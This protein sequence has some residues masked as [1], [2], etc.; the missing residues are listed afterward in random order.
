MGD[1]VRIKVC[2]LTRE[3]DVGLAAEL[4]AWAVGFV[5][6][7][8]SPRAVSP[9]QAARIGRAAGAVPRVGVFVDAPL[10]EL[11]ATVDTAGLHAVQLHGEESPA[12]CARVRAALPGVA[13]YK[14]LRL[15][16]VAELALLPDYAS[17]C[18]ALLIDAYV[19]G[20]ARGGTGRVAEWELAAQAA[21]GSRVILAG[22]L[23][24]VNVRQAR[25]RV[26][27][28]AL[29]ASSGLEH[30]PGVKSA[31]KMRQFFAQAGRAGEG[32]L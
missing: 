4:G 6:C 10:D 23:G 24:P 19:E 27:P 8:A 14:A 7:A 11:R 17:I 3:E 16:D 22:G 29:D 26:A 25:A 18:D 15:R 20:G 28:W 1:S 5:F 12:A 31:F 32:A 21:R 13:L 30:S 9:A 2:G